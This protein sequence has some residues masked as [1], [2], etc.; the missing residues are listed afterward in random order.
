M[1][2]QEIGYNDDIRRSVVASFDSG[3]KTVSQITNTFGV[4]EST[5]YRWV[6]LDKQGLL[7]HRGRVGLRQGTRRKGKLS[8]ED[9]QTIIKMYED[10]NIGT[11]ILAHRFNV[12]QSAIIYILTRE[13]VYKGADKV[14]SKETRKQ[15]SSKFDDLTKEAIVHAYRDEGMTIT[16]IAEKFNTSRVTVGNILK[17]FG[18]KNKSGGQKAINQNGLHYDVNQ[19]IADYDTGLFSYG[20][21]AKAYKVS[22]RTISRILDSAGIEANPVMRTVSANEVAKV[23]KDVKADLD[24]GMSVYDIAKKYSIPMYTVEKIDKGKFDNL[25]VTRSGETVKNYYTPVKKEPVIN[26]PE[27]PEENPLEQKV[28][29]LH[30][31]GLI[32]KEIAEKAETS[33][34]H[35]KR[36]LE[37]LHLEPNSPSDKRRGAVIAF[38]K[39]GMSVDMIAEKTELSAPTV[40]KMLQ[41]EGLSVSKG[42]GEVK[43]KVLELYQQGLKAPKIA[44]EC[45]ISAPTVRKII[46][47]AQVTTEQKSAE[48]EEVQSVEHLDKSG[49]C[50]IDVK[51]AELYDGG[52]EVEEIAQELGLSRPM[53]MFSL[54]K[55][56]D[57]MKVHRPFFTDFEITEIKSLAHQWVAPDAI[58]NKLKCH[59]NYV[60]RFLDLPDKGNVK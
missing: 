5:V 25:R 36:I 52:M 18:I 20:D 7:Y 50:D 19:V 35:V 48:N 22:T 17:G 10:D 24:A 58:S 47:E 27:T 31:Q 55:A 1:S 26:E 3:R 21:L 14:Y 43:A 38:C 40:R 2:N 37:K 6:K 32:I 41:E 44:L 53:V 23:L 57:S 12:S 16:A 4:S 28:V 51:I 30:S 59:E 11:R 8:N 9:V 29:E 46:S 42:N 39:Q 45:G 56:M 15:N 33:V 49:S 13:G 60:R 54:R 34:Y